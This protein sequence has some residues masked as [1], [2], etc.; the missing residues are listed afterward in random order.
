MILSYKWGDCRRFITTSLNL[1]IYQREIPLQRLPWSFREAI[2]VAHV[3][4]F[5]WLW[6]DALCILQD[7]EDDKASQINAMDRMFRS[8]V[9]ILYAI[10]GDNADAGLS[11]ERDP[12]SVTMC[13]F[14]LR[15]TLDGKTVV[16]NSHAIVDS[17]YSGYQP[18]FQRG[19]VLQEEAL[20]SRGLIFGP[21][22]IAFHC[23]CCTCDE[24]F[25]NVGPPIQVIQD[26]DNSRGRGYCPR[27][28]LD[29]FAFLRLWLLTDDPLPICQDTDRRENH[30]EHWYSMVASYSY[31][32]LMFPDHALP[33]LAGLAKAL[34]KCHNC[35]YTL[36]LWKEDLP[37]GLLWYVVGGVWL[38]SDFFGTAITCSKIV[39]ISA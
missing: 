22:Q 18:L 33:A 1:G 13:M 29:N 39:E 23:L 35:S 21:Q 38:E 5:R 16:S 12:R 19:W 7:S 27:L 9:L 31:R 37:V 26:P 3:L 28:D 32:S 14:K 2:S 25:P 34:E 8:S 10:A 17:P 6:I 4:G 24:T 20:A 30:F 11:V 36:G 15:T